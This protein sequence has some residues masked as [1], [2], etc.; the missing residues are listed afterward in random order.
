MLN[1]GNIEAALNAL[2]ST[3]VEPVET[4]QQYF[5]DN[6]GTETSAARLLVMIA[7]VSGGDWDG[8][9]GSVRLEDGFSRDR[10]TLLE[11]FCAQHL[12]ELRFADYLE[13]LDLV[14]CEEV[15][16]DEYYGNATIYTQMSI[17]CGELAH[18]INY[19]GL[20]YVEPAAP[21]SVQI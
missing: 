3:Q 5:I 12:P 17:R 11:T 8:D 4:R 20:N 19:K 1:A 10:F 2:L 7:H 16:H 14:K 18:F 13:I 9:Y 21:A 15:E 6:P